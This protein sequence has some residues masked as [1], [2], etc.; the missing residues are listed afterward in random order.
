MT[1]LVFLDTET[2]G[3][4]LDDDIWEIAAIVRDPGAPDW[5]HHVFVR[6]TLAKT[7]KLPEAF[8]ADHDTRYDPDKALPSI[9]AARWVHALTMGRAHI[10]GAVPNFDTERL[11]LMM[12]WHGIEPDWHYHLIDVENLAIGWLAA[13]GQPLAPPWDSDL[14]SADLGVKAPDGARH[15]ALGDARWARDIY[16]AVMHAGGR[17]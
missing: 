12:R 5:E 15:T 9:G 7:A 4:D 13:N 16:D 17:P 11:A 6:H 14:I 2:T 1:R 3:L 10:V 8:R